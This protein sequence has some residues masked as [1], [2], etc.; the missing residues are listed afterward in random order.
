MRNNQQNSTFR[1]PLYKVKENVY[2]KSKLNEMTYVGD[3]INEEVIDGN[4]FYVVKVNGRVLKL[5]KE[6]YGISRDLKK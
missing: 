6:A 2:F 1:R 3:I 4:S 5:S